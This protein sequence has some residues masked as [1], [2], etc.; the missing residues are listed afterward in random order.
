M[1][2]VG[3]TGRALKL[4]FREHM[5]NCKTN[6]RLK[7]Y[8]YRHFRQSGHNVNNITI[9]PVEKLIFDDNATNGFK[10][11]ARHIKELDWIKRLQSPFPLG[12]NDNIYQ[13]GNI[14]KEPSIDIFSILSIR[15]R[16]SR[17]HGCRKNHNLKRKSRKF[18]T[19]SDLHCIMKRSGRHAML[20]TLT[21]LSV[22]SL[23]R[24]DEE[25]D[26][27][28]DRYHPF[29]L[30]ASFV[31]SYTQ[32]ILRPHIDTESD[33]K[34]H[35]LKISFINKG[36]DFIN[37]P[38]IFNDKQ[39]KDSVPKYFKNSESPI[40]CYKYN[41]PVRDV[42]FNYN[43]IVS[44]LNITCNTPNTCECNKSKYCYPPSGH[45][46]TGNFEL[47]EDK[48]IR[49]LFFKGPKYRLPS[50]IDFEACRA[51]IAQAIEQFS[52]RWCRREKA[53]QNAL[54]NWKKQVF[55]IIEIRIKFYKNNPSLLPPRPRLSLRH[56][57]RGIENFHS[58]FVIVP[59]DKASNNFIIV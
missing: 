18:M 5:Y 4:R 33:H 20:T 32:H 41:K 58:K 28:Y 31:Q 49:K 27:I 55:R 1:Q 25:A 12:L 37:L 35:F 52:D 45:I 7:N 19:I 36:I 34:R 29:I 26:K 15:K 59:A 43:R 30:T 17:S 57:K 44:D 38:S 22:P 46:I 39:V 54:S 47:I 11:K 42:L 53:E 8:V 50:R 14:S 40:I 48:R 24:L 56:L 21:S 9:H 16:K 6:T 3:Q 2:Y 23:R 51:E 10:I 13:E